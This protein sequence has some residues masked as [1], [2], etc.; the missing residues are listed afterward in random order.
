MLKYLRIR[1]F[2]ALLQPFQRR[3]RTQRTRLFEHKMDVQP[4]AAVLDLGGQPMIWD[5]LR[6]S[7][8]LTVLNLPGIALTTHRSHHNI[9]Y[10]EGDACDVTAFESRAFDIV[11]SNSVIEHV[12]PADKQ[13]AFAREV[14]RLGKAYWVQTPS[15][16][17]PIEPHCGMPFWWFYP[18]SLQRHLLDRW[19]EKLPAWTEM[20]VGTTVLERSDMARLFPEATILTERVFGIPKSYIACFSGSPNT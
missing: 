20:V 7:V 19:H 2:Y 12:G 13:E 15:K 5:S 16:W 14:R 8:G 17:F 1:I 10:V 9:R 18:V 4:G 3:A 6:T 11:F